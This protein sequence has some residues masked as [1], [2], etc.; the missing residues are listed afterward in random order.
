MMWCFKYLNICKTITVNIYSST[1]PL[2][3]ANVLVEYLST[4]F[5]SEDVASILT[6]EA[7]FL[8]EIPEVLAQLLDNLKHNYNII[9]SFNLIDIHHI[10]TQHIMEKLWGWC[11][12]ESCKHN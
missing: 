10:S 9:A 5:T 11:F 6:L 12:H 4:L 1:D 7:N 8:P 2:S 3:K